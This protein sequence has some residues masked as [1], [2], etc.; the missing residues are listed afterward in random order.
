M[1]R[2]VGWDARYH[3]A[4]SSLSRRLVVLHTSMCFR[5]VERVL[6][7]DPLVSGIRRTSCRRRKRR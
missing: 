4:Q 7:C 3:V 5:W 2:I 6:L 1:V